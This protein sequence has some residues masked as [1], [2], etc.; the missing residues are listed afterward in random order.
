MQA[1]SKFETDNTL[2]FHDTAQHK[3]SYA[4]RTKMSHPTRRLLLREATTCA[5]PIAY[6]Y[7]WL[8]KAIVKKRSN[9]S[10]VISGVKAS[11][12][13][14]QFKQSRF[15]F[16]MISLHITNASVKEQLE[17]KSSQQQTCS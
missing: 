5:T 14:G 7:N 11:V 9:N 6:F 15:L 3:L 12:S 4:A 8:H 1:H 16:S 13:D 2:S 17:D 10:D